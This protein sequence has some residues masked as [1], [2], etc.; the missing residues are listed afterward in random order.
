LF[1][2]FAIG[3]LHLLAAPYGDLKRLTAPT[4]IH[5]PAQHVGS[6]FG[7]GAHLSAPIYRHSAS[8]NLN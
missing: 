8:L 5:Q 7:D 2:Q 4:A 1:R 6:L 3:D